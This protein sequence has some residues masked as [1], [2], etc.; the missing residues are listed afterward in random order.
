MSNAIRVA[1]DDSGRLLLP[2]AVREAAGLRPGIPFEVTASQGHIEMKKAASAVRLV[3]QGRLTV[4]VA[5]DDLPLTTEQEILKLRE[6]LRNSRA[7]S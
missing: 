4:A 6:D 5:D 2:E 7:G 1:V 3:R